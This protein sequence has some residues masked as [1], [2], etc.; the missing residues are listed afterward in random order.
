MT[1]LRLYLVLS[2]LTN[3]RDSSLTK[4]VI[5]AYS[6]NL[7]FKLKYNINQRIDKGFSLVMDKFLHPKK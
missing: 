5:T 1:L 6:Y 7:E 2:S 4:W 3:I